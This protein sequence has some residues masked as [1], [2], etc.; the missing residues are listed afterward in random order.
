M[1]QIKIVDL[2]VYAKHGVKAEE[3][4]LGQKFLVSITMQV[5]TEISGQTDNI[6]DTVSYSRVAHMAEDFLKNNSYNLIEAV[7]E[8]LAEHLLLN[9]D[10]I[11]EIEVE[12]KKPWAPMRLLL[13]FVSVRTKRKW[14]AVYLALGSNVGDKQKNFED[15]L[16]FLDAEQ[17]IRVQKV[18]PFIITKPMAN[19]KQ[20]DYLNGVAKIKTLLPPSDLLVIINKI[21][22]KLGR[23]RTTHWG[24]RTIDLDILLYDDLIVNTKNLTIPHYDFHNREFVLQ[25]LCKIAPDAFHPLL[26]QNAYQM[27]NSLRANL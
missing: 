25:S 2:Q 12:V 4:V 23:V 7:V 8:N 24:P 3:K 5:D 26:N 18:S 22:E 27:L 10:K 16:A 11:K 15:A 6:N 1:S 13:E 19:M 9:F 17:K 14:H 20:D 21:E